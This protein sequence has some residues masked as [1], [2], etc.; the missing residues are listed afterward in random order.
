MA[1]LGCY[2]LI[3][4]INIIL[5]MKTWRL[6]GAVF[7]CVPIYQNESTVMAVLICYFGNFPFK[8]SLPLRSFSPQSFG[9]CPSPSPSTTSCNWAL[10]SP[11]SMERWCSKQS[12]DF[13]SKSLYGDFLYHMFMRCLSSKIPVARYPA[14]RTEANRDTWPKLRICGG[15]CRLAA[16]SVN[17]SCMDRP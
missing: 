12:M 3:C 7:L 4:V 6:R 11:A 8:L 15:L 10:A 13:I 16:G 2:G 17:F 1:V 9:G 5:S 14:S